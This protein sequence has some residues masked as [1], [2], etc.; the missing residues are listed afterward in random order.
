MCDVNQ[1]KQLRHR[2]L[3][4]SIVLLVWYPCAESFLQNYSLIIQ[5]YLD[6]LDIVLDHVV[7]ELKKLE[8]EM[9]LRLSYM[10]SEV[11]CL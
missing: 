3:P 5:D 7:P 6:F 11:L 4:C 1:S 9:H 2:S 10:I 8:L